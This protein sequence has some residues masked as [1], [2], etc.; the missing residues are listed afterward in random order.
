MTTSQ[1]RILI[2]GMIGIIVG[3]LLLVIP[4]S[5]LIN[6]AFIVIGVVTLISAVPSLVVS[7]AN[8]KEKGAVADIV[9]SLISVVMGLILIFWHSGIMMIVVGVYM[10]IFPLIRVLLSENK[11]N[12]LK[13]EAIRMILGVV[14]LLVGPGEFLQTLIRVAGVVI[15]VL[16]LVYVV[17][18]MIK[19]GSKKVKATEKT[20]A[21]VFVDYTGDGIADAVMVDTTGDGK[22]DTEIKLENDSSDT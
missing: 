16:C 14:M 11:L 7:I 4:V 12:Q 3:I 2:G 19:S 9:M 6:V 1:Q 13:D 15:I 5:F 10:L 17:I 8:V 18:G 22:A 21:R 20:G